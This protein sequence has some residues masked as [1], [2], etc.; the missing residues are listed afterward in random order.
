MNTKTF[1]I[2]VTREMIDEA[3]RKGMT[4][5]QMMALAVAKS[6]PGA[7]DIVVADKGDEVTVEFTLDGERIVREVSRKE[8]RRD[9]IAR[10]RIAKDLFRSV[11]YGQ[12]IAAAGQ[13]MRH[14]R[15]KEAGL[16]DDE[17]VVVSLSGDE[18]ND[19]IGGLNA[20]QLRGLRRV[21]EGTKYDGIENIH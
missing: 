6:I 11:P 21:A 12:I 1:E 17:D 4:D 5:C 8:R 20:R 3:R 7:S 13:I 18:I 15:L 9:R 10:D 14:Q 16:N 2:E 19:W